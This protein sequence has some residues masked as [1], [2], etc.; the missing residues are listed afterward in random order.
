MK[1]HDLG[2]SNLDRPEAPKMDA[3]SYPTLHLTTEQFPPLKGKGVGDI[4]RFEITGRV[5]GMDQHN[6]NPA[7]YTIEIH[8]AAPLHGKGVNPGKEKY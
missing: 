1:Y 2:R 4:C 3:K 6:D 7:S 8:K 5:S